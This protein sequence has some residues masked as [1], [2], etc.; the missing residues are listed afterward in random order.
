VSGSSVLLRTTMRTHD[1]ERH[2]KACYAAMRGIGEFVAEK[3]VDIVK[4][5]N[6]MAKMLGFADYYDYK[7]TQVLLPPQTPRSRREQGWCGGRIKRRE[8]ESCAEL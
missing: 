2:R 4:G 5:R 1:D 3:F 8:R 6:R 7:V